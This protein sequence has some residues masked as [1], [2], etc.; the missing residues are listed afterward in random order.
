MRGIVVAH[1]L[2]TAWKQVLY[3][4]IGLGVL[5]LYIVFIASD[6]DIVQGYANLFESMPPAMLQA[7]GASNVELFRT[8]EGWIVS[9]FVSEAAIFLSVFAVMAGLNMT[10]NEEQSGIMDV[11]LALP[12]SRTA[13]LVERW[14]GCALIGLGIVLVCAALTLLGCSWPGC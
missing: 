13:Y 9:I 1:T 14:I 10:A 6:T 12:I 4:G 8:S 2:K 3:W 11:I 7:F 5:G